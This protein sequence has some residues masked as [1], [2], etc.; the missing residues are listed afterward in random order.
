M[1]HGLITSGRVLDYGCGRCA[2]INP[3][4]WDSYDPYYNNILLS[5]GYNTIICNYVLCVLPT[6]DERLKVLKHIHW[7]LYSDGI[8]YISVRNDKPR[9]GWGLTKRGTYQGRVVGLPL[10]MIYKCQGFRIYKLTAK[11]KL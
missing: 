9:S 7:L 5:P 11:T 3:M 2:I 1:E 8:A 4:D 6:Q 10:P